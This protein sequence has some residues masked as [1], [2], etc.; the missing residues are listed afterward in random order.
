MAHGNLAIIL[1]YTLWYDLD[2]IPSGQR[3]SREVELIQLLVLVEFHYRPITYSR[4][5][6]MPAHTQK[7][8][9]AAC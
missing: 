3:M 2:S 1:S 5:G 7:I 8:G 4:A 9:T 6:R